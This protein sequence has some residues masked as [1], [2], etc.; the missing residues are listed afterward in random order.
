VTEWEGM[1]RR[2]EMGRE[3]AGWRHGEMIA[4]D[5]DDDHR[6]AVPVFFADSTALKARQD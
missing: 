5:D 4:G 1:N 2:I 6:I 3:R